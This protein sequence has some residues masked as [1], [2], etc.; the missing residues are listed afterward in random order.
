MLRNGWSSSVGDYPISGGWTCNGE[1]FIVLDAAG[2]I[3]V[4]NGKS[5]AINWSRDTMHGD[6][7]LALSLIHI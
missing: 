2:S 1:S 7:G 5:G 6:G 3:T 4:F